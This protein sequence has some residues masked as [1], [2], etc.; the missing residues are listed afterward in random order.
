MVFNR[1]FG[2]GRFVEVKWEGNSTKGQQSNWI[3]I[4]EIHNRSLD[5]LELEE[6]WVETISSATDY[7]RKTRDVRIPIL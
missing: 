1:Q 3:I 5:Q 6:D 4:V 2:N 7:M